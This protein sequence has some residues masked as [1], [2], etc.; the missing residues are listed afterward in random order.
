MAEEDK[1]QGVRKSN[2]Q[3]CG[4]LCGVEVDVDDGGKVSR[5]RPD[6][7]R[8]PYDGSVMGR[9]GRFASNNEL[10][11]HPRRLNYP[12]K[13]VGDRGAGKWERVTWAEAMDDI[14]RRLTHQKSQYGAESLSTCIG[15]PHSIYWPLHRFMNLWG[16]PN[17]VG[18]GTVCWNP[19][20]WVNALTYGWPVEDELDPDITQCV[21]IWGMN[22]AESDRSLFWSSLKEY[23]AKGHSIVVI[24]PR[25]T[26]TARLTDFWLAVKPGTDGALA[27][28]MLHV[29][30][31]ENLYDHAF[32]DKWCSGFKALCEKVSIHSPEKVSSVTGIPKATLVKIARLY[33]NSNRASIFTG[34]GIDM[35]GSNCTQTLRAV[36][37]LRAITGNLDVPGGSHLSEWPDFS[38][39]IDMEMT[40]RLPDSQRAKKLGDDLFRLQG[41]RGYERLTAFT[42]KHG[43]RLPARY[44]TSAHPHLVWHAM[45][46]GQ[47]YPIRSLI[48]MASNPLLCQANT[49]L[50][51]Q[52][53]KSLDLL[54]VL[55]HFLTPTAMLADYIMPIAGSF[56]Q[57]VIQ[58]NGGVANLAYGGPAAI[59]PLY[60]RRT[61]YDFWRDL[62]RRC[63]Q[64]SFWPWDTLEDSLREIL[65]P[66][67][68]SWEDFASQGAYAPDRIYRKYKIDGFSTPS[69]KVELSSSILREFGHDPLPEFVETERGRGQYPL[70]LMTGVRK[71]PYYS[72]EFRQCARIRKKHPQPLA[73][74]SSATAEQFGLKQGDAVWV[75]TRQGR[76]RQNVSIC[77]MRDEIISIEYGWWFPEKQEKE[78]VLGGLYESNA[79]VLTTADTVGCDPIFGQ[80]DLRNIPCR[81]YKTEGTHRANN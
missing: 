61:D 15:A 46:S 79:N 45:L 75:E 8:F 80:Y 70:T 51:H 29:I 1:M 20:I 12:L 2:C 73:Q 68:V 4:Y 25:R 5:I 56:E 36:A 10:I 37:A 58:T 78:P 71:H 30:I 72:S 59:E 65:A 28:G 54:I 22:P 81:I 76:I 55:E 52:A 62:G 53:I 41:Y 11:D 57:P 23:A 16:S 64:E 48:C 19:R 17:N 35:S 6:T 9:C 60:E 50:V 34:L 21:L 27:M 74:V 31:R 44:L 7:S 39:E 49:K 26:R 40:H 32:V 24:D 47:P 18:I 42:E 13:R 77:E 43:K 14:A 33:A 69:G 67:G 38:P 63:G 66:A 3:L